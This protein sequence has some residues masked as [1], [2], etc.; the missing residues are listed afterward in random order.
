MQKSARREREQLLKAEKKFIGDQLKDHV[1]FCMKSCAFSGVSDELF[2]NIFQPVLHKK[3][4]TCVNEA[5]ASDRFPVMKLSS[6][7][8]QK[9]FGV[10]KIGSGSYYS[11]YNAMIGPRR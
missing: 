8:V 6:R 1:Q 2:E 11:E 10:T 7:D 5:D 3:K 4:T 9:L